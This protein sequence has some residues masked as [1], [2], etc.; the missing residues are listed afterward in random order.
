MVVGAIVDIGIDRIDIFAPEAPDHSLQHIVGRK[1]IIGVEDADDIAR[2]HGKAFVH[3]IV[4]ALVG[5]TDPTHTPTKARFVFT[6]DIE[7]AILRSPVDDDVLE[8]LEGLR[9]DAVHRVA[10]GALRI[11]GGG[12]DGDLH[13]FRRAS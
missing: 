6:D 5:F 3:R 9:E 2:G 1:E 10:Q 8:V 4:D 13:L 12:D 7:G 11:I